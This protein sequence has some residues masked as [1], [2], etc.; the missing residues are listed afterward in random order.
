LTT[1]VSVG[2]MA[3][4]ATALVAEIVNVAVPGPVGVPD[5]T[6]AGNNVNPAG[7]VPVD[8][9]NVGAGEPEAVNV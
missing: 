5:N 3:S 2:V 7:N 4:G 6:P 9:E 8:T 1:I